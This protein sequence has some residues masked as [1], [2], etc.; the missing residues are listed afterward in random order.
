MTTL[1]QIFPIHIMSVFLTP[2]AVLSAEQTHTIEN[3]QVIAAGEHILEHFCPPEKRQKTTLY[4]PL[5]NALYEALLRIEQY[6]NEGKRVLIL[7]DGDPLYFGIGN[8]LAAKL[9]PH[10]LH[11]DTGVSIVQRMCARLHIPW[12]TLCHVS[13]HGRYEHDRWHI[14]NKAVFSGK[15]VCLLTDASTPPSFIANYLLE[16]GIQQMTMHVFEKL[17]CEGERIRSFTLEEAACIDASAIKQPCSL[18]LLP[19]NT[20]H[21]ALLGS[22]YTNFY[23]ENNLITKTPIRAAALSLL[24][25]APEHTVWDIGAGSGAVALEACALAHLGRVVAVE[26]VP[27]RIKDI[28]ANRRNTG[29]IILEICH[30]NAPHCLTHLPCPQRIFVGGGLSNAEKARP[31]LEHL[32]QYLPSGG[33]MV[34]S[35]VLLGTLHTVQEFFEEQNCTL[36]IMHMQCAE[37]VPFNPHKKAH[38][39]TDYRLVPYNPVFLVACQKI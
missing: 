1:L 33:R 36:E 4:I 28:E 7:A 11:I 15:G 30:G 31:L 24:H 2:N 14:F 3:A 25:I 27:S 22:G 20:I 21:H 37:G 16:R 34:I 17:D 5:K 18:L 12:H 29:A 9:Q 10:Q 6:H 8:T 38:K 32:W 13:L 39:T 26:C 35:C 19:K 23:K